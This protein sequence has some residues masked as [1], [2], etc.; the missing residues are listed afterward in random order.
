MMT[1]FCIIFRGNKYKGCGDEWLN[2][3]IRQERLMKEIETVH[4]DVLCVQVGVQVLFSN[5]VQID[6]DSY[7]TLGGSLLRFQVNM[8]Q[9]ELA[10]N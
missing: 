7:A 4:P 6:T 10:A 5:V 9:G 1:V 2:T 3:N 8:D